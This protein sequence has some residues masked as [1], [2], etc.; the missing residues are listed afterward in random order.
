MAVSGTTVMLVETRDLTQD[1]V[2]K[3]RVP[4]NP[5]DQDGS[6][7][8]CGNDKFRGH[9]RRDVVRSSE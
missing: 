2:A 4:Y 8:C 7:C 6:R 5:Q 9:G 1:A 3:V